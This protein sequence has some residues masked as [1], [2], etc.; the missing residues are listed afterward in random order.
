MVMGNM[1]R[2]GTESMLMNHYRHI[3]RN[4]MQFDFAVHAS[5]SSDFGPEILAMGGR[6]YKMPRFN[7]VN[8][9]PYRRA[10]H[11]FF[12][13]HPE[14][15]VVHVH[16][17]LV[18]GIVLPIAAKHGVKMR[19]V[20]SHNTKPPIFILKEK[21]MWLFHR[22]L[23]RYSTLRLA[24]SEAAGQ[25][26]FGQHRY[27]VFRNAIEARQ[28]IYDES[29][30]V[31]VRSEFGLS[32]DAFVV[33]HIGSFRTRQKNHAFLL[34]IFAEMVRINPKARLL[35]VGDGDL[36][37]DIEQLAQQLCI[38]DKC[39]FAG[40]RA[41]VPRLMSAM[42]VFVFPSF[43]EG[44]SVVSV[45]VQAAGLP[46]VASENVTA[47][48][49]LTDIFWQKSLQDSAKEWAAFA[50]SVKP[51]KPRSEYA[52]EVVEAGYDVMDNILKLERYYG[53]KE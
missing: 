49:K 52:K 42:D 5:E 13:E 14:Y 50:L 20:H 11:R 36:R 28:F 46:C 47:E 3:D 16:H 43:F 18:A 19:I 34:E 21:V 30:S 41:D 44:L 26:L 48:S 37:Q 23:I 22:D 40:V 53:I 51:R 17:F 8:Y 15:R 38:A 1:D 35:L 29:V 33:G 31:A 39:I 7:V 2:G 32:S 6:I 25:Y 24:C 10:W 45:E 4:R 12:A 27:E 9:F